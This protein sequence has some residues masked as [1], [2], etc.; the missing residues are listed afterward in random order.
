[1]GGRGKR[2]KPTT[3][4]RGRGA[5]RGNAP[6]A[7]FNP[8][9]TPAQSAWGRS[10]PAP[11]PT[12]S[13]WGAPAPAPIP[14]QSPWGRPAP[15]APTQSAWGQ[16]SPASA[17]N[18]VNENS[19]SRLAAE[20]RSNARP[21]DQ[22]LQPRQQDG[23]QQQPRQQRTQQQ[24]RQQGTQPREPREPR[25][26]VGYYGKAKK[27]DR[28]S[29]RDRQILYPDLVI[30]KNA[31]VSKQGNTGKEVSLTTNHFRLIKKPNWQLYQYRVDFSPLIELQGFMNKLIREQKANLGAFLFD[32]TVLFLG[33]KLHNDVTEYMS[34]DRDDNPIQIKVKFV[35]LISML[36]GES[37]QILNLILRRSMAALQ[38]QLV[39]RNFFDAL[40]KINVA[41]HR[42]QLWPGYETSVRQ[43][44]TDILLCAQMTTKVMRTETVYEIMNKYWGQPN[45]KENV[46]RA[47][48][49]MTVL[50]DYNNR[51]YK[52]YDITF[53]VCPQD[54]FETKDGEKT[55][56]Q[57]YKEKHGLKIN[58]PKQPM[59]ITRSKSR[60][61]RGGEPEQ[62]LLVPE[63]C[64]ATGF[65]QEMRNNISLMNEVAKHTRLSP[66]DRIKKLMDFNKR[67]Q[68]TPGSMA[69]FDEWNF[70]LD[71]QLVELKG[72][73]LPMEEI[74]FAHNQH[75]AMD[76]WS[77]GF[78]TMSM[79][80][81]QPLRN[82][83]LIVPKNRVKEAL[84][85]IF[86]LKKAATGMK[87]EIQ[88]PIR[89]EIAEDQ[90]RAY[91]K[92]IEDTIN[93]NPQLV[94]CIMQ[95]LYS[96]KYTAIKKKCCVERGVPSQVMLSR[97]ITPKA[98]KPLNSLMTVGTK[99]AIQINAKL[100]GAPWMVNIPTTGIMVVG[101]DVCHDTNDKSKSYG[102]LVSTMDMKKSARY[103]SAVSAHQNGEELCNSF[104]LNMA[105]AVQCYR[106][107]H[108]NYPQRIFIYRDGVGEGQTDYVRE[109]EIRAVKAQLEKMYQGAPY[110]LLFVVVSKRINTRFF[111][112]QT[113]PDPGTIV[114]NVVTLPER[115]DFF[116]ISQKVRQG[117]VSPTNYNILYNTSGISSDDIQ[118]FTYK[119]THLYYN[120]TSTLAVPAVCQYAHKLAF[121]V[122]TFI[123]QSPSHLLEK[124]L[125]FL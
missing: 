19:S 112:G 111:K 34:K 104:A 66:G 56:I 108:G 32:G 58:D 16:P 44:E 94:M 121:L 59:L 49:G 15:A 68:T 100:G 74:L 22:P 78:R 80:S 79:Y 93:K 95:G 11:A 63:L 30:T 2:G 31:G 99:V 90:G 118:K 6:P 8:A 38:L 102:A 73:Q 45:F 7:Q 28:G 84:D 42:L 48:L 9:P 50:T 54:K 87:Y 75:I 71:T 81:Q 98:N 92:A 85:F 18:P 13:A 70:Q 43:H 40:A 27:V 52:V 14:A 17:P 23:T 125:Y 97:T 35:K 88:D 24:P 12:H 65:T 107:T 21:R 89:V 101:F 57:Y 3:N 55:F 60:G 110:R 20:S 116:L 47:V 36:N 105:K 119:L 29:V 106:A 115:H 39:G 37:I 113:N 53:D 103:F 77:N 69:N 86:I 76:D 67:L 123:H 26:Y 61:I 120:W 1:M 4:T 46:A 72:R 10:A 122:G 41:Q 25:K 33:K 62:I 114:D 91:I 64:R 96:D 51:T 117:T 83:V 5:G 109:H 124:Q 82:W